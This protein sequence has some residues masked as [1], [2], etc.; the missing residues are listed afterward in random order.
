MREG[1]NLGRELGGEGWGWGVTPAD[2]EAELRPEQS[3]RPLGKEKGK[4][5][6]VCAK[7]LVQV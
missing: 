5:A 2:V 3:V 1:Y 6:Q 4:E 7:A